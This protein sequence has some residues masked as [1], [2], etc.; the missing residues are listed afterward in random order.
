[1]Q[2][3]CIKTSSTICFGYLLEL[4]HW[5]N[6]NKYPKHMFYEELIVKQGLS[7][8]T[9]CPLRLLY[10][11]KF[12]LMA[13]SLATNA[14]VVTR[15][16]CIPTVRS[17]ISPSAGFEPN[18]LWL[19]KRLLSTWPCNVKVNYQMMMVWCFMSLSTLFKSYQSLFISRRLNFH[20]LFQDSHL[21]FSPFGFIIFNIAT[22]KRGYPHNI[23]L[24]SPRKHMLWVLIRSASPRSWK[25]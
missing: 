15:V 20:L 12:I 4:P 2:E 10:N 21:P 6:S 18:T 23:F 11:R 13:T 3:Y 16:H 14:V 22:D 17:W 1:M 9:F 5:G 19:K 8:I 24:I 25:H 7:Y